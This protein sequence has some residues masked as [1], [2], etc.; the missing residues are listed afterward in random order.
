MTNK[1]SPHLCGFRKNYNT[2]HALFLLIKNW[3]T[4]LDRN[5]YVGTLLM[6]L[7]KA[8]D[9][10]PHDLILAKLVAYGFGEKVLRL[11]HSYLTKRKQ[12]VKIFSTLSEFMKVI[13][14][15][16]QG[17]ILG[18]LL[19]NIFINDLFPFIRETEICNFADDN[20]LYGC[21]PDIHTIISQLDQDSKRIVEWFSNNSM[22]ANP[23]KF[24]LMFL[25]KR[26]NYDELSIKVN[27]ET[28]LPKKEVKLLGVTL[29]DNLTF[30]KHI[31]TMCSKANNKI[32]AFR[33]MRKFVS[34]DKAKIL[35]NAFISSTF[36]YCPLIWMF[37][38][39]T[40][41]SLINKTHKRALKVLYLKNNMTLTE[42]ITLDN[43]ET[44]HVKNLRSLLTE[45]FKS[46]NSLSPE[47]IN[48][49]FTIKRR[50]TNLRKQNALILPSIKTN[51]KGTATNLY[52]CISLWNSLNPNITNAK[53]IKEFKNELISW[54]GNGCICKICQQ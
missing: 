33:R 9:C 7:S 13:F 45:V 11:L 1:L 52:R 26:L 32:S 31:K 51:S 18:P 21:G 36:N 17:S 49:L 20:T 35:Y 8:Y 14:G 39:K 15:V 12:R 44:I 19:F 50:N 3:Q 42:L 54:S 5:G 38:S 37:C 29:D 47:F 6:D 27:G 16:P 53:T 23:A 46:L 28:L 10:L 41:N 43:S 22:I 4:T 40:L 34:L 2:Q 24:Q 30:C 48:S 25:G